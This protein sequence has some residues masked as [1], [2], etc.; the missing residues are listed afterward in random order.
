MD[1]NCEYKDERQMD[2]ITLRINTRRTAVKMPKNE[3]EIY[4]E[5]RNSKYINLKFRALLCFE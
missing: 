4:L 2:G 3:M 5:G 1:F